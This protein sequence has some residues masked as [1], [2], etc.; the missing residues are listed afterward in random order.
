MLRTVRCQECPQESL[1]HVTTCAA[2]LS[3]GVLGEYI[4]KIYS[5]VQQRPRWIE[6]ERLDDAARVEQRAGR[7]A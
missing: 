1:T 6:W 3:I 5:T 7:R 4:G 2:M